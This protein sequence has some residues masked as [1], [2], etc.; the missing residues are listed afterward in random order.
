MATLPEVK[1]GRKARRAR[2]RLAARIAKYEDLKH[3]ADSMYR[4]PGSL[5]S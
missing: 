5:K 3:D 1:P 2:R 4:R